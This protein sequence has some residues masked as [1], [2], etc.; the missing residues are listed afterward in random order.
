MFN[1][2]S[3]GIFVTISAAYCAASSSSDKSSSVSFSGEDWDV[4]NSNALTIGHRKVS[5]SRRATSPRRKPMGSAP[6]VF[7][8]TFSCFTRC[9]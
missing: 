4:L 9:V 8:D 1:F 6:C 7:A 5:R 2:S 3:L